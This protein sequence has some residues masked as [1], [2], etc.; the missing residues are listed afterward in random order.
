MIF[1]VETSYVSSAVT[2]TSLF[3]RVRSSQADGV[4]F[5]TVN[6]GDYILLQLSN[7]RIAA[8]V[9]LGS[10][11]V[12]IA[13]KK[14]TYADNQ[15]HRVKLK[16]VKR[17]VNLTVDDSEILGGKTRGSFDKFQLPDKKMNFVI[18]GLAD[19]QKWRLKNLSGKNFTGCLQELTFNGYNLIEKYN[20]SAKEIV[21]RGKFSKTC[22]KMPQKIVSTQPSTTAFPT[23]KA[24]KATGVFS[25]TSSRMTGQT[26]PCILAGIS[27]PSA[28][29]NIPTSQAHAVT[30]SQAQTT[31]EARSGIS[32]QSATS[33]KGSILS[34]VK[35]NLKTNSST[36]ESNQN[37]STDKD[38]LATTSKP[39]STKKEVAQTDS[40]R[41][42]TDKVVMASQ[43]E[44][45]EGDLTLYFILAAVVGL[46]AFLLA[47]LI[48]VK[49][50]SASKKKYAIKRNKSERDYWADTGS[51]HRSTKESKP[52]V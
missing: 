35:G 47:I 3:M 52:L 51:F 40:A 4:F 50:S 32:S 12:T 1:D 7:G 9:D 15:W 24:T 44:L 36:S 16:R 10:G 28:T 42:S 26:S 14:N 21:A 23:F 37:L 17:L 6:G 38:V 46:V 39:F 5:Y 19:S 25:T 11:S 22:P 31:V 13:T 27:C 49:V 29:A 20:K 30:S 45:R 41:H 18:G 34:T 2:T 33:S 8:S 43:S 48:I